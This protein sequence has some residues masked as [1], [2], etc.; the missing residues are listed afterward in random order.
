MRNKVLSGIISAA[1]CGIMTALPSA[2]WAANKAVLLDAS[3]GLDIIDAETEFGSSADGWDSVGSGSIEA[4]DGAAEISGDGTYGMSTNIGKNFYRNSSN[5]DGIYWDFETEND[6]TE[7]AALN[8]DSD[9]GKWTTV[10]AGR[11]VYTEPVEDSE[12]YN[13]G[14][15]ENGGTAS[16]II[17]ADNGVSGPEPATASTR[18]LTIM[19]PA[20]MAWTG[21][22]GAR[23]RLSADNLEVGETY[24][25]KFWFL[26]NS[27]QRPIY[28]G[29]TPYSDTELSVNTNYSVLNGIID[30]EDAAKNRIVASGATRQWTERSVTFTPTAEDFSDNGYTTLWIITTAQTITNVRD[31][32]AYE[33]M[34]LD[35]VSLTHDKDNVKTSD[36]TFTAKLRGEKG[37]TVFCTAEIDGNEELFSVEKT[38]ETD[39]EWENV[40]CSFSVSSDMYF[41]SGATKGSPFDAD[42]SR[43]KLTVSSS[44]TGSFSADDIHIIK[45]VS[46]SEVMK[47]GGKKMYFT[48]D[49]LGL[50]DVENAKGVC[51]VGYT[52][53]TNETISIKPGVQRFVLGG[54]IPSSGGSS[55]AFDITENNRTIFEKEYTISKLFINGNNIYP[56]TEAFK[57]FGAG[58]YLVEF[59]VDGGTAEDT[60][61]VSIG[62]VNADGEVF[63]KGV[64]FAEITLTAEDIERLSDTDVLTIDC[65]K[66]VSDITVKKVGNF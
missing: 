45:K 44:G 47:Y 52:K 13:V 62:R 28:F 56:S 27:Q 2:A 61:E 55:L 66:T 46:E 18:C 33:K 53:L 54:T 39:G 38:F 19:N 49:V 5:E 14:Y 60:A 29:L 34:Y 31:I 8:D 21:Y 4:V 43:I 64:G 65:E 6:H 22:M 35:N 25:L 11:S 59:T 30:Y 26:Q 58:Q 40:D 37:K 51:K 32:F 50:E 1:L 57:Y 16:N 41:L 15:K 10:V 36:Y 23:V 24:T 42:N 20:N 48:T 63:E 7:N 12:V 17:K 3:A 9:I